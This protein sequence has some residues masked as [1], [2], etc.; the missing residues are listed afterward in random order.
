MDSYTKTN[1]YCIIFDNYKFEIPD[2]DRVGSQEDSRN[3]KEVFEQ[4]CCNVEVKYNLKA[5]QMIKELRNIS[6]KI[7][8]KILRPNPF[9]AI[10]LSHGIESAI[11]GTDGEPIY[12]SQIMSIFSDD[13]CPLLRD[14]LKIF[15]I[16]ACRGGKS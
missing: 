14:I 16:S 9:V 4:L 5:K 13:N 7:K 3:F 12:I 15:I 11:L 10:F 1:G 6:A 8:A 2:S